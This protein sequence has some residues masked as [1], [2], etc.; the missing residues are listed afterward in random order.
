MA[1]SSWFAVVPSRCA[2]AL[3]LIGSF[4]TTSAHAEESIFDEMRF[5]VTA[6]VAEGKHQ[7]SGLFP[8]FTVFSDPLGAASASS[9]AEKILRPRVHAGASVATSSDSVNQIYGGFS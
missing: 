2:M 8:S 4:A 7:E 5:G 9:L 1:H 3:A 6:P